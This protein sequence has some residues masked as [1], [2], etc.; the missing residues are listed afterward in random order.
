MIGRR[1]LCLV[2]TLGC[3]ANSCGGGADPANTIDAGGYSL[4]FA[5][6]GQGEPLVVFES[7]LGDGLE[8][9]IASGVFDAVAREARVIAYSRAGYTPSDFA[10]PPR[11]LPHLRDDLGIVL[12][13]LAN[14]EKVVLVGHSLGGGIIRSLAVAHPEQVR[15]LVFVDPTHELL[16]SEFTQEEEDAAVADLAGLPAAAMEAE[17]LI[18]DVEF[19]AALP[20]LPDVPVVVLTST[21]LDPGATEQ[22]RQRVVSAHASLGDGVG[23]FE[24]IVARS[25]GHYI[26]FDEPDIVIAAIQRVIE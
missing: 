17:Q 4:A 3:L 18:E 16:G 22:D 8:P 9:W 23:D 24:H 14:G 5:A 10:P 6:R 12:D 20:T 7:G 2:I 26:H 13:A 19:L 1:A 11:D 25:A 15:A 21:K